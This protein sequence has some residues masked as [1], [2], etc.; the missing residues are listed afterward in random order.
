M[1]LAGDETFPREGKMNFLDNQ[2]D[3]ATGTIRGRA[4]FRNADGA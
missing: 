2:L 4:I 3:P 1:A